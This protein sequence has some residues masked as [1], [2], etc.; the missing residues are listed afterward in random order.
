MIWTSGMTPRQA[1]VLRHAGPVTAGQPIEDWREAME[2]ATLNALTAAQGMLA[3]DEV[4]AACLNLTVWISSGPDFT[5]H[6]RVADMASAVLTARLGEAGRCA[7]AAVGASSLP[8]NAPFEV[9]LLVA[10][11]RAG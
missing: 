6:S 2:L 9:Q 3:T 1:G 4:I 11:R 7:R 10:V 8:G 5:A